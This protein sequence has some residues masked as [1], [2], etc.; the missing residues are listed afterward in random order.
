[1]ESLKAALVSYGL[2]RGLLDQAA[3]DWQLLQS[4][5]LL[6]LNASGSRL[7]SVVLSGELPR[8]GSCLVQLIVG[9]RSIVQEEALP[10]VP[11]HLPIDSRDSII[12]IFEQDGQARI[13]FDACY[14]SELACALVAMIHEDSGGDCTRTRIAIS[15]EIHTNLVVEERLELL[16]FHRLFGGSHPAVELSLALDEAG[17][18]HQPAPVASWRQGG[19]DRAFLREHI[20]GMSD[21]WLFAMTSLRDLYDRGGTPRN[22]GGDFAPEAR[23]L[24]EM[25]ARFHLA[26]RKAFGEERG[27]DSRPRI[28]VHGSYSLSKVARADLAWMLT[29]YSPDLRGDSR[30]SQPNTGRETPMASWQEK[31]LAESDLCSMARSFRSAALACAQEQIQGS[32]DELAALGEAWAARSTEALLEGYLSVPGAEELVPEGGELLSLVNEALVES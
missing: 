14:D 27:P 13:A 9:D 30:W 20:T 22:A 12:G 18:N 4:S 2:R 3:S 5:M 29:D 31:H 6:S 24:G 23:R 8:E 10:D 28:R 7:W 21:G 25:T 17:F 16:V 11:D 1:M 26:M 15:N 32:S 19:W